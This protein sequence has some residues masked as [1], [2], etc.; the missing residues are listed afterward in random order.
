MSEFTLIKVG[1]E[2]NELKIIENPNNYKLIGIGYSGAV[3]Q[4]SLHQCV[5]VYYRS[6]Y[7]SDKQAE[8]EVL[9]LAQHSR[10]FPDIYETGKNYIVMEY[11]QGE[12]LG[13]YLDRKGRFPSWLASEIL[14]MLED[15][16][17][18]RLPRCDAAVR[19]IIVQKNEK[20]IKVIDHVNSKK[21]SAP[22]PE[23]LLRGLQRRGYSDSFLKHIKEIDEQKYNEWKGIR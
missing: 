19:H 8:E 22:L 20:K 15:M 12:D 13:Q 3:F 5:K 7:K 18:L 4:L 14:L 11:I 17:H 21:I 23:R 6:H 1:L 9:K 2:N 10:F 16:K